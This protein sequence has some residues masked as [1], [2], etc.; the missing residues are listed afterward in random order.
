MRQWHGLRVASHLDLNV[1]R[2]QIPDHTLPKK[3]GSL[4]KFPE[5]MLDAISDCFVVEIN[6]KLSHPLI[7]A[8]AKSGQI[9]FQLPSKRRLARSWQTANQ[10]QSGRW[11]C[12]HHFIV[13]VL[14][15]LP[16]RSSASAPIGRADYRGDLRSVC[17]VRAG[18]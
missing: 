11:S 3:Q 2:N 14:D 9:P 1:A 13:A 5:E 10:N 4:S 12:R 18:R 16:W 6:L 8:K 17:A 15:Q 7:P